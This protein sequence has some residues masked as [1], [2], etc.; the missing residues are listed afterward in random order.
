[1]KDILPQLSVTEGERFADE[2]EALFREGSSHLGLMEGFSELLA[3]TQTHQIEGVLATNAP[4]LNAELM[5]Q[6]LGIK[7]VFH[8]IVLED[9]CIAGK[10]DPEPYKVALHKLGITA[11]QAIALED[12]SPSGIRAAVAANNISTI[13]IASTH[14][15]QQLQEEGTLM[16][17]PDFTDLRLLTFLNSLIEPNLAVIASN[18]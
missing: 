7:E 11:E 1:M 6:V 3:W 17:I 16:A 4:R 2:K 5:V 10:P 9:D 15:P 8:T 18:V 14:D 13:G 12:D